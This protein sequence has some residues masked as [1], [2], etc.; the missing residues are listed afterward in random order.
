MAMPMME[1]IRPVEASAR[2]RNIRAALPSPSDMPGASEP[3]AAAARVAAMA[4]VA[5][6]E[7]Q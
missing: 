1:Q 4:M 2:G 3:T 7:P 5:I 6:M